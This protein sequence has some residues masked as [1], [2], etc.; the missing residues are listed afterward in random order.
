MRRS[1]GCADSARAISVLNARRALDQRHAGL[2]PRDHTQRRVPRRRRHVGRNPGVRAIGEAK[3]SGMTPTT[4]VGALS[5][6]IVRPTIAGSPW[7]WRRHS[8][9]PRITAV[10]SARAVDDPGFAVRQLLGKE[11]PSED[12]LHT[13]HAEEC[14]RDAADEHA[15]G[16][17]ASGDR[18]LPL[19]ERRHARR[20]RRT[21]PATRRSP[22]REPPGCRRRRS[23]R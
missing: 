7:N 16:L 9:A 4:S 2:Q 3:P 11:R 22:D 13:E 12:G 8:D 21:R 20:R 19:R 10:F 17:G 15:L 6:R 14:R 18:A 23:T 5:T 1:S